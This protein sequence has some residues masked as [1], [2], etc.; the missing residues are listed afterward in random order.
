M[1]LSKGAV[2]ATSDAWNECKQCDQIGRIFAQLVIVFI[3]DRYLK[4]TEAS[5]ILG[6]FIH[7]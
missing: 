6:F 2:E 7:G 4:I 3:L 1:L 5:R